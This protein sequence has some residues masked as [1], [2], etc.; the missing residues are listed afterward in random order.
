MDISKSLI[1]ERIL[2]YLNKNKAAVYAMQIA[3]KLNITYSHAI[4]V[5]NELEGRQLIRRQKEGRINYLIL[6][7]K[8]AMLSELGQIKLTK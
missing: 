4:H 6:T 3:K 7:I 5:I 8:G 1:A 2:E